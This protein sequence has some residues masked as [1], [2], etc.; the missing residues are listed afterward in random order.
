MVLHCWHWCYTF[1]TVLHLN[2]TTL[3][4]SESSNVFMYI[5]R[6]CKI[7]QRRQI[8]LALRA[9]A[10][11]LV[12]EKIYSC[13]FIP[14]CTRNHLITYTNRTCDFKKE[15]AARVRFEITRMIL[16]QTCI[17]LSSIS[18]LL[19]PFSFSMFGEQTLQ[20]LCS[21]LLGWDKVRF[22]AENSSIWLGI[23][24]TAEPES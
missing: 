12:F 24:R 8:A 2:C 23:N 10:I 5:I 15:L 16:D 6:P 11:L 22:K 1:C 7:F 19:H 9:R 21:F 20:T 18:T 3:S 13:L 17:P 14:N 4:Q